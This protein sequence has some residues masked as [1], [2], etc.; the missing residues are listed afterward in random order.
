MNIEQSL[1]FFNNLARQ[2][3][4]E[5][6]VKISKNGISDFSSMDAKFIM[7]YAG[8]DSEI[9]DLAS[10]SG[11]IINKINDQVKK[12]TAVEVFKEFSK[13]IKIT[14]N[15]CIINEDVR[16][17]ETI[18]KFDLVTMFGIVQY[19]NEEE[20][21]Q[22]YKKYTKYLKKNGKLIIKNQ[23]G[24]EEDVSVEGFSEELQKNYYSEYRYINKETEILKNIGFK[25][26][27]VIDIYP[28]ECN[29]WK[30]THFYAIVA[31]I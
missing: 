5:K 27:E 30:N 24:I 17:F 29:R 10:G 8:K 31:K 15:I 19:F 21:I 11:L 20:I 7:K 12:I 23:F 1:D 3:P 14:N 6:S 16:F 2:N 18:E 28:P 25:N 4:N 22:L 26:I 13:F 9:L